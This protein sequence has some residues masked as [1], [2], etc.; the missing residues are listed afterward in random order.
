MAR[1]ARP[2]R[3]L[4]AG[5]TLG[6]P[7]APCAPR[8]HRLR[9]RDPLSHQWTELGCHGPTGDAEADA[10]S[11]F[12]VARHAGA[13]ERVA[14][15]ERD[16]R[17]L[18]VTLERR[19]QRGPAVASAPPRA[20]VT[21]RRPTVAV[22][23]AGSRLTVSR[24]GPRRPDPWYTTAMAVDVAE[25]C[26]GS[27]P[28]SWWSTTCPRGALR[29]EASRVRPPGCSSTTR[30]ALLTEA[31]PSAMRRRV[32]RHRERKNARRD[33]F[34]PFDSWA[35]G[36]IGPR[37]SRT[38]RASRRTRDGSRIQ[39]PLRRSVFEPAG[40]DAGW[41]PPP[42]TLPSWSTSCHP[43]TRRL[44]CRHPHGL[45]GRCPGVRQCGDHLPE[46]IAPA[47]NAPTATCATGAVLPHAASSATHSG[48]HPAAPRRTGSRA[49]ASRRRASRPSRRRLPCRRGSWGSSRPRRLGAAALDALTDASLRARAEYLA[50][51]RSRAGDP[52]GASFT[53]WHRMNLDPTTTERPSPRLVAMLVA[54]PLGVSRRWPHAAADI[55]ASMRARAAIPADGIPPTLHIVRIGL[56]TC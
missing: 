37:G 47:P 40:S 9:L 45:D 23:G 44:C 20:P 42:S 36:S 6:A 16:G 48:R 38:S 39:R 41:T 52:R 7:D 27:I 25:H 14:Y 56:S 15:G 43:R 22:P 1:C 3:C 29:A 50:L 51:S 17:V 55:L 49:V 46:G 4:L 11:P 31:P 53:H 33:G 28:T 2:G 32:V 24:H 30:R 54:E 10:T 5:D 18:L 19:G 35:R 8:S 34:A 12:L 21:T 26:T 13:R